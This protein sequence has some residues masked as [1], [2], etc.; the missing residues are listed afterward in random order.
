MTSQAVEAL[1]ESQILSNK[2]K[3]PNNG[4]TPDECLAIYSGFTLAKI[5]LPQP[6]CTCYFAFGENNLLPVNAG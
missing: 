5:L 1:C 4:K 3:K 6:S 2:F